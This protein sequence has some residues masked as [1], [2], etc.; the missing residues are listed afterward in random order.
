MI[1][2]T[3][4]GLFREKSDLKSRQIDQKIMEMIATQNLS[5][6]FVDALG[7]R[8]LIKQLDPRYNLR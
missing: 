4:L 1:R 5:F 8:R 6:S 3:I 2:F 7:F